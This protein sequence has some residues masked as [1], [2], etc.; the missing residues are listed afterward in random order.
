[1]LYR[2]RAIAPG[3]DIKPEH[4]VS[5]ITSTYSDFLI[6]IGD[7]NMKNNT[8]QGRR[9]GKLI[10]MSLDDRLR[11][12]LV[13]WARQTGQEGLL[14]GD[15]NMSI[16]GVILRHPTLPVPDLPSRCTFS[17]AGKRPSTRD[18]PETA[19]LFS[20]PVPH[21]RICSFQHL[22]ADGSAARPTHCSN[23]PHA[24]LC[25]PTPRALSHPHTDIYVEC[26]P[27]IASDC[28]RK[29]RHLHHPTLLTPSSLAPH[30][31]RFPPTRFPRLPAS[32]TSIP[33]PFPPHT[34][35]SHAPLP[36]RPITLHTHTHTPHTHN[37]MCG[38]CPTTW[39]P[40]GSGGTGE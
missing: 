31:T 8:C 18:H 22:P 2:H 39:R 20:P 9:S 12:L 13:E 4:L 6:V 11:T 19:I 28:S 15:V 29:N 23:G 3:Q 36:R 40:S 26:V 1:M 37:Q 38:A 30:H 32:P 5:I 7:R 27:R 33:T 16:E 35:P 24:S 21:T 17:L 14:G 34:L 10:E 25:S